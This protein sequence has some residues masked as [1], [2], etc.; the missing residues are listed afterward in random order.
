MTAGDWDCIVVGAGV[1]GSAV[2]YKMACD[3]RKVL[4]LGMVVLPVCLFPSSHRLCFLGNIRKNS[5]DIF[6]WCF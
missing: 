1:V 3:G 2:A 5:H 6:F 4:L